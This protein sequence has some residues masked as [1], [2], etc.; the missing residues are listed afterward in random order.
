MN[1]LDVNGSDNVTAP[2]TAYLHAT[3]V[4]PRVRFF[5]VLH[6]HSEHLLDRVVRKAHF[7][8]IWIG[9]VG[10]IWSN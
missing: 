10:V 2:H 8:L 7:V 6:A 9:R 3:H 1:D 4:P 5:Q